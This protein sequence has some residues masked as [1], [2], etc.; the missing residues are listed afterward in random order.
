[1][2]VGL[3]VIVVAPQSRTLRSARGSGNNHCV[4]INV[5]VERRKLGSLP[6]GWRAVAF[7][8]A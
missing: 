7:L 1:M 6:G 2:R 4:P 3:F 8:C 5:R